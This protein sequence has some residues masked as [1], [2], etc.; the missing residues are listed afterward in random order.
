MKMHE[1][2]TNYIKLENNLYLPFYIY[3]KLSLLNSDMSNMHKLV[4]FY[5]TR[6]FYS[7]IKTKI[8]KFIISLFDVECELWSNPFICIR[9]FCSNGEIDKIYGGIDP[10]D[11]EFDPKTIKSMILV[12]QRPNID[13]L[14]SHID[15]S[16]SDNIFSQ[17]MA[18]SLE[19][20]S[21]NRTSNLT[22]II[23]T[24]NIIHLPKLNTNSIKIHSFNV[25]NM[26]IYFIQTQSGYKHISPSNTKI[27]ILASFIKNKEANFQTHSTK[28]N[29]IILGASK[30][31]NKVK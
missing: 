28:A 27:D 26:Y 19:I 31:V 23:V 14:P 5:N 29:H 2:V 17:K 10:L 1:L 3:N 18:S 21:R 13:S 30:R 16:N 24:L 12:D 6:M 15:H 9:P 20:I 7:S 4:Q 11:G 22:L 25:S 8:F